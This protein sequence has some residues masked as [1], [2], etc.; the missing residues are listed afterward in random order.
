MMGITELR[1]SIHAY[2]DHADKDLLS[3]VYALVNQYVKN[4]GLT[5][6]Y[7]AGKSLT[8]EQ[9]HQELIEAEAEI[10]RGDFL[11]IEEFEK[12]SKKWG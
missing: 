9:L 4:E 8:K 12:A 11:T 7:R 2:I 6:T 1:K 5:I 10:E 3:E